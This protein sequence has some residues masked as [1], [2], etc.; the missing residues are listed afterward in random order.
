MAASKVLW[1][2]SLLRYCLHQASRYQAVHSRSLGAWSISAMTSTLHS[3]RQGSII[4]AAKR[5]SEVKMKALHDR[6]CDTVGTQ[7]LKIVGCYLLPEA[8]YCLIG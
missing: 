5:L 4:A 6:T 7:H 8:A 1:C 3:S 2:I